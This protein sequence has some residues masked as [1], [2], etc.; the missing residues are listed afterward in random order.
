M[1]GGCAETISAN[2]LKAGVH[3]KAVF[4]LGIIAVMQTSRLRFEQ[5]KISMLIS[6]ISVLGRFVIFLVIF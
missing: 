6:H 2:V 5:S 1:Q 4:W 3:M